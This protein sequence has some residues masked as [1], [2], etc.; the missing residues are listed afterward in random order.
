MNLSALR[1]LKLQHPG[2]LLDD[3][4]I[5][6]IAN[7]IGEFPQCNL[8]VFGM[9]NDSQ[10]W[11]DINARGR[12]AFLEDNREWFNRVMETCPA[13]EACLVSYNTILS[14]WEEIMDDESRLA[15]DL[16]PR[17]NGTRWDVIL[18][19]GPSGD[20]PSYRKR[21]GVEPP[22]RMCSIYMSSRL[23]NK[24]GYVF[25]H[26]CNRIVERVYADRYL[27]DINLIEQT[28]TVTQLRKYRIP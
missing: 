9:G 25:V 23:V 26:D 14:Q 27:Y 2:I 15:M 12:T 8:L 1:N 11:L 4:E 19:D 21:H 17:I 6:L 3:R 24:N 7:A 10:L 16:P 5:L 13:A 18:V 22:G 20:L 28:R